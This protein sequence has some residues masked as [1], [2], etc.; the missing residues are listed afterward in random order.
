MSMCARVEQCNIEFAVVRRATTE[1]DHRPNAF[2]IGKVC[3]CALEIDQRSCNFLGVAAQPQLDYGILTNSGLTQFHFR[4]ERCVWRIAFL[5]L[6]S[7]TILPIDDAYEWLSRF[8]HE[9]YYLVT[10]KFCAWSAFP[11]DRRSSIQRDVWIVQ[12]CWGWDE[13]KQLLDRQ[14]AGF[15]LN[16][17]I[18]PFIDLTEGGQAMKVVLWH[19]QHPNFLQRIRLLLSFHL[20]LE[21]HLQNEPNGKRWGGFH[22]HCVTFEYGGREMANGYQSF[23]LILWLERW[24]ENQTETVGVF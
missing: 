5:L 4:F 13:R 19:R 8:S 3:D 12:I 15:C 16:F 18:I 17:W 14:R 10:E 21:L 20:E 7:S 1:R 2:I 11:M 24:V 23:R 22:S 9:N 6:F